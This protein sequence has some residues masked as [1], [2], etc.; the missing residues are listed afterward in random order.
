MN[1]ALSLATNLF[2]I[3]VLA[4]RRAGAGSSRLVHLVQRRF[5]HV[6]TRGHHARHGHHVERGRFQAG[7]ENAAR[8]RHR[9]C[10]ALRHHAVPRLEH[11]ASAP[12]RNA[13]RRRPDSR[14]VLSVRHGV[15][16]GQLHRAVERRAVG[17]DDDV[18]DARR[19]CDDAAADQMAGGQIRAGG[20]AGACF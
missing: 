20:R 12:A 7:A 19:D 15:E 9:L 16:R 1:R 17:A 6:G 14:V 11:R 2:P 5:H 13:V 4:R 18:L 10:R 8:G 3:W